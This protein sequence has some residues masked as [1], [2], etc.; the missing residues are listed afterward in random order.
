MK[1]PE[2]KKLDKRKEI[3]PLEVAIV[4]EALFFAERQTGHTERKR[5]RQ[6]QR[7]RGRLNYYRGT[8]GVADKKPP[9]CFNTLDLLRISVLQQT[10]KAFPAHIRMS[11]VD[12][13]AILRLRECLFICRNINAI[14]F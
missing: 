9:W 7:D 8:V 4:A 6:K 12:V 3:D 13:D 14:Q 10:V 11:E 1:G 2:G 5:Q